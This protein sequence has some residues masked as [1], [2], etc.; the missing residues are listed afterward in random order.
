MYI[1]TFDPAVTVPAYR[2]LLQKYL[3]VFPELRAPD[4]C[5]WLS[6][7]DTDNG[8]YDNCASLVELVATQAHH[9]LRMVEESGEFPPVP[10]DV[11]SETFHRPHMPTFAY[12]E[13][14]TTED[15]LYEAMT[16]AN[17][18][19]LAKVVVLR[20]IIPSPLLDDV[21]Y[22]PAPLVEGDSD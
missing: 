6:V 10:E 7:P 20:E 18:D 19:M 13:A 22:W 5:V 8:Q 17:A 3:T 21:L 11:L 12:H 2:E 14:A 4:L 15:E 9:D 1:A 16:A